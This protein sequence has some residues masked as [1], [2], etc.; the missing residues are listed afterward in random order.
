LHSTCTAGSKPLLVT[1]ANGF[2]GRRLC[3]ALIARG[4]KVRAFGRRQ[5]EGSWDAFVRTDLTQ[6]MPTDALNGADIVFHLAGKAHALAETRQDEEAYFRINTEGTR[7]VLE[8]AASAGVRRLVMFSSVKAMCE[9]S[10][11]CLD[12]S[13]SCHPESPYG[14]SKL[15]AEKLVLEG[16]YVPE[17]VVLRLSM[18]YGNSDKGNLPRMIRAIVKGRFPPLPEVDNRRSMVH[19]EDV[20]QAAML[21]AEKPEAIGQTYI[22]TDGTP[23]STRQIYEWICEALGKPVPGWS[24]PMP[25]LHAL[26]RIGDGIG[27]LCGRRF[28]FDSDALDKLIGS[29]CYTSARLERELGFMPARHLRESLPEIVR[30]LEEKKA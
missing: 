30:F 6:G 18:V 28:T 21:A 9:G 2:I 27:R 5:V 1:G 17:P 26:A 13:A 8:A 7:K 24:I 14:A 23:Y 3:T 15:A 22:V 25:V 12:E 29:A 20:V 16:G 4:L 10:I 19:V 11:E